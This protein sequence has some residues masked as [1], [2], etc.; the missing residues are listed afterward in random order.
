MSR[1]Q[2]IVF[3]G[4]TAS[5]WTPAASGTVPPSGLLSTSAVSGGVASL[6]KGPWALVT[7]KLQIDGR[8]MPIGYLN[9][10]GASLSSASGTYKV[11]YTSMCT[12]ITA[13]RSLVK[14]YDSYQTSSWQQPQTFQ[15]VGLSADADGFSYGDLGANAWG[16][17][18]KILTSTPYVS[19]EP[20]DDDLHTE[21]ASSVQVANFAIGTSGYDWEGNKFVHSEPQTKLPQ[22]TNKHSFIEPNTKGV[23]IYKWE[24]FI[25]KVFWGALTYPIYGGYNTEKESMPQIIELIDDTA[26]H[27]AANNLIA[28]PGIPKE[29]DTPYSPQAQSGWMCNVGMANYDKSVHKY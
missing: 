2:P 21:Y 23:M 16:V 28:V 27:L 24:D 22:Y 3:K 17:A 1:R 29:D 20:W 19:R 8:R 12:I 18:G 14:S 5:G 26:S 25:H 11:N 13:E 4:T 15:I 10:E 6:F 9:N 7:Q